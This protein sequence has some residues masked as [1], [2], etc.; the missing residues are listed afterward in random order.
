MSKGRQNPAGQIRRRAIWPLFLSEVSRSNRTG[1]PFMLHPVGR[2]VI[3]LPLY[4]HSVFA[5]P[6]SRADTGAPG[7]GQEVLGRQRQ[8]LLHLPAVATLADEGQ[9]DAE[10]RSAG[11]SHAS[12]LPFE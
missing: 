8:F 11:Q 1:T 10:E 5:A 3:L 7:S 6:A 2:A 4:H 12:I 9:L